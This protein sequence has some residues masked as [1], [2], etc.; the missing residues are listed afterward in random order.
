[1]AQILI[2][3]DQRTVLTL[4]ESLLRSRGHV[5]TSVTNAHDAVDKLQNHPCDLLITDVMMPGGASGFDLAKTVRKHDRLQHLPIIILTGR[6]EKKDIEAGI[7]SGADDY[8][9]KP[10]DPDVLLAKVDS[11]LTK[12][13]K[14]ATSFAKC[15]VRED[16]RWDVKNEIVEVSEIGLTLMSALPAAIGSKVKI[17]SRFFQD[18]GIEPPTLRVVE[19]EPADA[20]AS[21]YIVQV[22]FVG[23][24][25]KAMTPLRI[26]IRS[27]LSARAA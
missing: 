23:L 20:E 9:I 18:V 5:V 21:A 17:Q 14:P 26:W 22:H 27:R 8:V 3:D 15:T 10:I 4:I 7:A 25:E 19:C 11:L 6:R 2:A 12:K 1:M 24:T 13:Q 16:A